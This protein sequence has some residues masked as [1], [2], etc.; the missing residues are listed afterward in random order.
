MGTTNAW[1]MFSPASSGKVQTFVIASRALLACS[2]HMPGSL[3]PK[4]AQP[5]ASSIPVPRHGPLST[6]KGNRG[7]P[8]RQGT[9]WYF[10]K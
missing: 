3:E 2:V 4:E 5:T 9:T 10:M 6:L 8:C 7:G 1:P